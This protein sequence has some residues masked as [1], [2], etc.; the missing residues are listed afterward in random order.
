MPELGKIFADEAISE[1]TQKVVD[2]LIA[3]EL[4][5]MGDNNSP[6]TLIELNGAIRVLKKLKSLIGNFHEEHQA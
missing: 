6:E 3:E 2:A 5:I 4:I 1:G